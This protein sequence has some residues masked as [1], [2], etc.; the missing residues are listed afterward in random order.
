MKECLWDPQYLKYS[1]F[2]VCGI[3][4]QKTCEVMYRQETEMWGLGT[5][6]LQKIRNFLIASVWFGLKLF[7]WCFGVFFFSY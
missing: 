4:Y 5:L 3:L 7:E 6:L 1:V 2:C